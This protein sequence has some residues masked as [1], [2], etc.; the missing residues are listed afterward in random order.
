MNGL[1]ETV[2]GLWEPNLDLPSL[3]ARDS[4]NLEN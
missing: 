1:Q 4:G 2:N 3:Y